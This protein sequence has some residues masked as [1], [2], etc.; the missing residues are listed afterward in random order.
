MWIL[1]PR[2]VLVVLLVFLLWRSKKVSCRG[3]ACGLALL[4]ADVTD[5]PTGVWRCSGA[6]ARVAAYLAGGVNPAPFLTCMS[7]HVKGALTPQKKGKGKK[8]PRTGDQAGTIAEARRKFGRNVEV[9]SSEG[10]RPHRNRADNPDPSIRY[11]ITAPAAGPGRGHRPLVKTGISSVPLTR[12]GKSPRLERQLR[13]RKKAGKPGEGKVV[14]RGSREEVLGGEQAV[15]DRYYERH[16]KMPPGM[17][18]PLPTQE[19]ARRAEER[20]ERRRKGRALS[21]KPVMQAED[22]P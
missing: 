1:L 10:K 21:G 8:A 6:S 5:A 17:K 7:T 16:G 15:V 3:A 18:R 2:G 14:S 22:K 13:A 19:R 20:K 11:V 12:E 4:G 9:H